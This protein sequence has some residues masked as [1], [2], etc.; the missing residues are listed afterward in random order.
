MSNNKSKGTNIG[1]KKASNFRETLLKR[2]DFRLTLERCYFL[3]SDYIYSN[4]V[5]E[6][7]GKENTI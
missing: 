6:N 4:G 3:F 5:P 1:N 7:P 2:T